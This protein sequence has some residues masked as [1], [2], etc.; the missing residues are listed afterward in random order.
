M[1]YKHVKKAKIKNH[2]IYQNLSRYELPQ[3]VLKI[4]SYKKRIMPL[5][6]PKSGVYSGKIAFFIPASC[7]PSLLLLEI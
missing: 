5:E 4:Y 3:A 1:S 6:K 7:S 2:Y